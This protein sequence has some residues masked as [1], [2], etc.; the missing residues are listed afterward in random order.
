VSVPEPKGRR[1][2]VKLKNILPNTNRI[3][4]IY[5]INEKKVQALVDSI[6]A[7]G[8]WGNIVC[9]RKGEEKVA[10]AYGHHRLEALKQVFQDPEKEIPSTIQ[11]LSNIDMMK[12]MS[13]E[14]AE[15]YNCSIAATD[16]AVQAALRILKADPE[17]V[18]KALT[19]DGSEVKRVRIGAPAIAKITGKSEGTVERSLERLGWIER[20]EI[21]REALYKMPSQA[22]ADRFVKAVKESKLTH[23]EQRAVAKRLVKD[24]RFGEASIEQTIMDFVPKVKKTDPRSAAYYDILFKKATRQ[25]NALS[26]TLWTITKWLNEQTIIGGVPTTN[27][28]P[29]ETID[30]YNSALNHLASTLLI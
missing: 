16:N 17:E 14:N 29:Q 18:R 19:S 5:P 13:R 3:L 9:R 26:T 6:K 27:D 2:N 30:E 7:T 10:I 24:G 23:D 1:I 22:A 4:E 21:D 28:I 20:G 12:I 15:E 8:F 25:I 11:E